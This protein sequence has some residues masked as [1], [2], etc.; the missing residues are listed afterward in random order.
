MEEVDDVGNRETAFGLFV[1]G[2]RVG[3]RGEDLEYVDTGLLLLDVEVTIRLGC[4][5]GSD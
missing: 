3:D 2:E 1:T 4:G 5:R